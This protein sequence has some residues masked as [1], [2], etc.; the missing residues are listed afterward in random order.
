[1]IRHAADITVNDAYEKQSTNLYC[2]TQNNEKKKNVRV[3]HIVSGML[4]YDKMDITDYTV[5][6]RSGFE[7]Q[8]A[9]PFSAENVSLL[10]S[11]VTIP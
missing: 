3:Y 10:S 4:L 5:Q 1:M 6:R 11:H 8:F 9:K 7:C 2:S